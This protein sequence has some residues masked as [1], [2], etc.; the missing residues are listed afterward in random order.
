MKKI[1]KKIENEIKNWLGTGRG[2]LV[3]LVGGTPGAFWP[4]PRSMDSGRLRQ[5]WKT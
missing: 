1:K 4:R 3:R 5:L 2:V